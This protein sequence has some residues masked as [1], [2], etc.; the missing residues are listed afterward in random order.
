MKQLVIIFYFLSI[1][2]YSQKREVVRIDSLL[3]LDSKY[4]VSDTYKSL[5]YAKQACDISKK[6]NNNNSIF[7]AYLQIAFCLYTLNLHDKSLQY[8]L[9]ANKVL[10]S[11]TKVQKARMY[12]IKLKNF[13]AI[14]M[15]KLELLT[16]ND[17]LAILSDEH[18]NESKEIQART[19][20]YLADYYEYKGDYE[21]ANQFINKTITLNKEILHPKKIDTYIQKADVLMQTKQMDSAFIYLNKAFYESNLKKASNYNTFW[22]LGDYY[23]LLNNDKKALESYRKALEDMD[24]FNIVDIE[25]TMWITESMSKIYA[26]LGDEINMQKYAKESQKKFN[27][28]NESNNKGLTETINL[29]LDEKETESKI[30]KSKLSKLFIILSV[31]FII[32]IIFLYFRYKK[33]RKNKLLVLNQKNILILENQD[34]EAEKVILNKKAEENQFTELI[35]LAKN[36][37]PE[38]LI[39]FEELYPNFVKNLKAINPKIKNP[40]IYFCAL[41]FI[42][43]STKE[44]SQ[45]TFVSV[46]AVQLRKHRIRKKYNIP[47]EKDFNTVMREL[48]R[49]GPIV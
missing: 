42:N 21:K 27:I 11:K 6:I 46:A 7:E 4:E 26:H 13:A 40:E 35:L 47:S 41:A 36:N 32:F 48:N 22:A 49:T 17:I 16:I 24:K 43:L 44:I 25:S 1:L 15:E 12:E 33:L 30:Q 10:P 18:S 19:F 28:Y 9:K 39:L 5:T 45:Y 20:A 38:F 3:Q 29:I 37:N 8:L 2:S 14:K 34:L 31:I 23:I